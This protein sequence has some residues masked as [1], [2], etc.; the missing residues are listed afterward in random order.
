MADQV[1]RFQTR[2]ELLK[3]A[4]GAAGVVVAAPVL[5]LG[6]A[7]AQVA[8]PA[9]TLKLADNLFVLQLPG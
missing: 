5:R 1:S 8:A 9:N 3:A 6:Q 7:A 2:R 4:I